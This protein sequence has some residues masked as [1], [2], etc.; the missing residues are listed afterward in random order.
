VVGERAG[1]VEITS[2]TLAAAP[3]TIAV[4]EALVKIAE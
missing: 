3:K 2:K 1:Q 4:D